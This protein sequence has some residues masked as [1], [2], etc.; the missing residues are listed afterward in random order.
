MD[1][2]PST[3][4]VGP[5]LR[6]HQAVYKVTRGQIG[7]RL[8]GTPSLLLTTVGRK[9]GQKRTNALTYYRDGDAWVVVASNGGSDHPPSWLANLKADPHVL[10]R[11]GAKVSSALARVA[12]DEERARLWPLVNRNN[13][14]LAPLLH[15]GAHGRYDVY[16]R[17]TTREIPLVILAPDDL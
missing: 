1:R 12:S 10:V 3:L 14:G 11:D 8:A 2:V 6:V 16:Q 7:R 15:R 13:R 5:Y 17:R 4:V 9:T